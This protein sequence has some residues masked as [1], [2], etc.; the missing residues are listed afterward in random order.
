M[1]DIIGLVITQRRFQIDRLTGIHTF[2]ELRI[3]KEQLVFPQVALVRCRQ[4]VVKLAAILLAGFIKLQ[5][6]LFS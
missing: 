3:V 1:V 4:L 2:S 5:Q 6:L